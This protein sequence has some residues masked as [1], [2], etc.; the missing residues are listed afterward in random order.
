MKKN[1][2]IAN[3]L[4]KPSWVQGYKLIPLMKS[5]LSQLIN[6]DGFIEKI[7]ELDFNL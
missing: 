7:P 3:V 2:V 6:T 5:D 4:T 1:N